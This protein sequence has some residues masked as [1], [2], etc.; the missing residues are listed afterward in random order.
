MEFL[1]FLVLAFAFP[2]PA[3]IIGFIYYC[4][5]FKVKKPTTLLVAVIGFIVGLSIF[6]SI[7]KVI[8]TPELIEFLIEFRF[9]ILLVFLGLLIYHLLFN[10]F[11]KQTKDFF[12]VKNKITRLKLALYLTTVK[13][14]AIEMYV[15]YKTQQN[16]ELDNKTITLFFNDL[17]DNYLW[18]SFAKSICLINIKGILDLHYDELISSY[19]NH[20][21][22]NLQSKIS[23]LYNSEL[24]PML[25]SDFDLFYKNLDFLTHDEKIHVF[26]S[27]GKFQESKD[28]SI[29]LK[30][31]FFDRF[32]ISNY[33]P[34]N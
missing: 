2:V 7:L 6:A 34:I 21:I 4:W 32:N 11:E 25:I 27:F 31:A 26:R 13:K 16:K 12:S 19:A 20:S 28:S 33:K 10:K 17:Q 15:D 23:E 14:E 29:L 30:K 1:I 3:F 24:K 18:G 22:D 8:L 5:L 9:G